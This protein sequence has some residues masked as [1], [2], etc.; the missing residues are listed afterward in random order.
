MATKNFVPQIWAATILRTLE[1]NLVGKK[2]CSTEYTGE[3]KQKGDT[4]Y[5]NGLADPTISDYSDSVDLTYETL[6]DARVAMQINQAKSFAFKVTD[7]EKAQ[8]SVDIKGS[9]AQ[10]AAYKLSEA[11][12][13]YIMALYSQL[14]A[15]VTGTVT[16]ANVLSLIGRIK[17]LLAEANVADK[18][19]WIVIPPWL[20]LKLELAGI[21]FQIKNGIDGKDGMAWTDALGFD[22]YV[23]NQVKN[24]GTVLVPVSE[25][26]GGSYTAIAMATQ[27]TETENIRLQNTFADAV[28]GLAVFDAKI[29]KPKEIV[30]ATLTYAAET[31]I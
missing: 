9:Q 25:V 5:F 30:R 13:T 12:D 24:N 6:Q 19:T 7:I 21:K 15:G 14:T 11:I 22:L 27:I 20:K 23:T 31:T 1:N 28:R 2:I 18:D 26:M 16:T 10:R 17:Q 8:A 4:V 29:I 3:I